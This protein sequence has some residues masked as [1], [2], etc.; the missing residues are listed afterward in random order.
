MSSLSL[1]L[2]SLFFAHFQ[3]PKQ[4]GY[5]YIQSLVSNWCG[6]ADLM[7]ISLFSPF[8]WHFFSAS[9]IRSFRFSACLKFKKLTTQNSKAKKF[10][11]YCEY[12]KA[13]QV[14]F[15]I[16]F[17]SFSICEYEPTLYISHKHLFRFSLPFTAFSVFSTDV[18]KK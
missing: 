16:S 4:N 14:F 11:S 13:L 15:Q 12:L 17:T 6:K 5:N 7:T 9:Y 3:Q 1:S 2:P 8:S 10:L 18:E